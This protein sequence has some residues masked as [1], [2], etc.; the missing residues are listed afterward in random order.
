[1]LPDFIFQGFDFRRRVQFVGILAAFLAAGHGRPANAQVVQQ[2]EPIQLVSPEEGEV[3]VQA[4]WELRRG[5]GP[6]PDCSHFV[7]TIYA[8]VGLDYQYASSGDTFDGID[9]FERVPT[10]QPGDLIVWQGHMGI[11]VDPQ[12]HSF[13]SS[14][15][16]GFAIEDY[17][18]DYWVGRG[19]PR[20]YRYR[21]D[22]AHSTRLLEY[23]TTRFSL[24]GLNRQSRLAAATGSHD[25]DAETGAGDGIHAGGNKKTPGDEVSDA[26]VIVS[27]R[28]KPSKDEV[29]AAIIKSTDAN[30]ERLLRSAAVDSHPRIT[31]AD[32][33]K[34]VK[35]SVQGRSGWADVDV[36]KTASIQYGKP[37]LKTATER[38]RVTLRREPQGWTLRS[39]H[40]RMYMRS[41]VAIKVLA[42]H[43]VLASQSQGNRQELRKT[44]EVLGKLLAGEPNNLTTE[45]H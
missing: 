1:M 30:G 3:I 37:E 39:P 22:E 27:L 2:D 28:S 11:V 33:F 29:R 21:M 23:A 24:P 9:G 12:E 31:V 7:H 5:L 35:I 14:V 32:E 18:S 6:K 8:H 26:A 13:Y 34:V 19:R 36:R 38:W 15:S 45:E 10:P 40:D 20:F 25:A 17:R 42:G 43:L 16:A 4:A 41:D 44:V